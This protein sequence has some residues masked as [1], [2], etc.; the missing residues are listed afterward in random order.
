MIDLKF[1]HVSKRYWLYPEA[2]GDAA[3]SSLW[4]KVRKLFR[5]REEFWALQ[6]VSFEVERGEAVGIIGH[7]GA[8]KTTILKLLFNITAP[9]R[10][11]ITING[12]LSAL[13]EISSGFHPELTGRE[14]VYLNGSLLGMERREITKKLDEIIEFAEVRPFIDVPVKRYSLGMHL[15]LGFS[16]AAHLDPDILLL[17]EILTVGDAPFQAKCLERITGLKKAGKTIVFVSHNLS[18]VEA[19]CDRVLLVH[20][21]RIIK[22][23][24]PREVI[25]EYEQVLST[26][27]TKSSNRLLS[28]AGAPPAEVVSI[29]LRNS[30][31][32]RTSMFSTG[33]S[34]RAELELTV[35]EAVADAIVEVYFYSV[36]GTLHTH[37][38][39][40]VGEPL[41]LKPGRYVVEFF[42]PELSLELASFDV[43]ASIKRRGMGFS[44]HLDYKQ[45]GFIG[46]TKGKS[47]H[48]YFHMTHTW[49][50]KEL[51]SIPEPTEGLA[52][53]GK[54][55]E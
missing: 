7:N 48:G 36:F 28:V 21:G 1:D 52:P 53:L 19:L 12:R 16:I 32:Q 24:D 46:V 37:F 31:G 44:E 45:V 22:S 55:L 54:E 11:E 17:D 2:D 50:F 40:E 6:D 23:G 49:E 9:T 10:G 51:P 29:S 15:R 39:T 5:K 4:R 47:V 35:R 20:H 33:D 3:K 14:N 25:K 38:T 42:C 34:V 41:N 27:P 26:L 8:G 43:E 13:L 18:A 30:A